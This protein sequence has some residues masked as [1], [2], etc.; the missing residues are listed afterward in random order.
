MMPRVISEASSSLHS[1]STPPPPLAA[2]ANYMI[3]SCGDV[4]TPAE[5]RG[6]TPAGGLLQQPR[7]LGSRDA[8]NAAGSSSQPFRPA[9]SVRGA[10]STADTAGSCAYVNGGRQRCSCTHAAQRNT[11]LVGGGIRRNLFSCGW[12]RTYTMPPSLRRRSAAPSAPWPP[13]RPPNVTR[14]RV[15]CVGCLSGCSTLGPKTRYNGSFS[16]A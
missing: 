3:S 7:G 10:V 6:G 8:C 15:V 1:T 14:R 11:R 4:P 12:P 2:A 5:H 13:R 16:G 9:S